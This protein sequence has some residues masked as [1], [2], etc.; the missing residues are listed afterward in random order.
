MTKWQSLLN[1]TIPDPAA[2]EYLQHA[3][4]F[5]ML[6]DHIDRAQSGGDSF[7]CLNDGKEVIHE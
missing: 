4:A 3:C 6:R 1:Q 7:N 5:S 2:Q